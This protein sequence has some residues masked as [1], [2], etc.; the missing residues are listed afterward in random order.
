MK[1]GKGL[2][3]GVLS[4]AVLVVA[5]CAGG[6]DPSH[7]GV[8][9]VPTAAMAAKSGQSL[10]TVGQGYWVFQRK[11]T[12]CHEAKLPADPHEAGWHAIAGGMA[13]NAGLM[14]SEEKA[15]LAYIGAVKK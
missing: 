13:W 9:P 8:A 10:E 15:L 3:T 6:D 5:A 4:G 1:F 11:C 2:V 12:E 14:K 7:G